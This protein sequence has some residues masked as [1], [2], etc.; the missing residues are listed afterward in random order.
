MKK[1]AKKNKS[2]TLGTLAIILLLSSVLL[3]MHAGCISQKEKDDH[4]SPTNGAPA[5]K[6]PEI[7][8]LRGDILKAI[9][10]V[11]SYSFKS[12]KST[13]VG[14][15]TDKEVTEGYVDLLNK[16][17]K[18]DFDGKVTIDVAGEDFDIDTTI[19]GFVIDGVHYTNPLDVGWIKMDVDFEDENLLNY[20][21]YE[22][23]LADSIVMESTIL[24]G[25]MCWLV[26]CFV[27]ASD[28][29][30]EFIEFGELDE[31]VSDEAIENSKNPEI[32][33][34]IDKRTNLPVKESKSI[35]TIMNKEKI[36]IVVTTRYDR[37]NEE[38]SIELPEEAKSAEDI[39]ETTPLPPVVNETIIS[40]SKVHTYA[41][42]FTRELVRG[43][44]K[45]IEFFDINVDQDSKK[46]I[47]VNTFYVDD[48]EGEIKTYVDRDKAYM[49]SVLGWFKSDTE[50]V[51]ENPFS[52]LTIIMMQGKLDI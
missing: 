50:W 12:E 31:E 20:E 49:N 28:F 25:K 44:R 29:V 1:H 5:E 4:E 24:D 42:K 27:N 38:F 11:K 48:D 30:V 14:Q 46:L 13:K 23:Y 19:K 15:N 9:G 16:R 22:N 39:N 36:F 47:N 10:N 26:K 45:D 32:H 17:K 40:M 18:Y 37:Y 21:N 41:V 33:L 6:M 52:I 3:V 43:S 2:N 35:E 51:K 8:E 34:W 7:D